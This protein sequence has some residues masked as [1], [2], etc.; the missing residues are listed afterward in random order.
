MHMYDL[1]QGMAASMS[2][3]LCGK[4][5]EGIWHTSI[6]AFGKEFYYGGGISY[7]KIGCTPFGK[8][9]KKVVLGKTE[10]D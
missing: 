7:D 1:S 3:A 5:Y 2:E 9:T 4:Y 10:I 8:P 6:C